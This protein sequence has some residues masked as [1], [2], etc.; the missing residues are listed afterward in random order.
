MPLSPLEICLEELLA[1][2]DAGDAS[3]AA[4]VDRIIETYLYRCGPSDE[5]K[6]GALNL[7]AEQID[8][9]GGLVGE[10]IANWKAKLA[11]T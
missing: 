8:S 2:S 4:D 1:L 10:G 3:A 6:I 5:M 7:L 11:V 9:S